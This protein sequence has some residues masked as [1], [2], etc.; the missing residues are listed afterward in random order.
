MEALVLTIEDLTVGSGPPFEG[1]RHHRDNHD[2]EDVAD[3]DDDADEDKA[4]D[5][6]DNADDA[7]DDA[8]DDDDA[9]NAE[10]DN[11]FSGKFVQKSSLWG[12][13]CVAVN[14]SVKYSKGDTRCVI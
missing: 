1:L 5:D 4:D 13:R 14:H 2:D 3:A 11:D 6:A 8:D 7:D 10:A 9:D 12:F